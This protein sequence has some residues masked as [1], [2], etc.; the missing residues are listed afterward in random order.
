[1]WPPP[2]SP[3]T[4][5]YDN[6]NQYRPPDELPPLGSRLWLELNKELTFTFYSRMAA[7]R[8]ALRRC[9]IIHPS[10]R[11][12]EDLARDIYNGELA[13]SSDADGNLIPL[14][15]VW[16]FEYFL[17]LYWF[18]ELPQHLPLDQVLLELG[19]REL[20]A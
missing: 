12:L 10:W 4:G 14:P 5:Y 7:M 18:I 6:R 1:M 2:Q 3:E 20:C 19:D 11:R 16:R 15:R 9:H 13:E 8:P 17:R